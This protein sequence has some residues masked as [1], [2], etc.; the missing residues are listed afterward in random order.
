MIQSIRQN[1]R[2]NQSNISVDNINQSI[3]QLNILDTSLV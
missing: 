1:L 2:H 3:S